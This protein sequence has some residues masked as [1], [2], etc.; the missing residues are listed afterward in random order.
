MTVEVARTWGNVDGVRLPKEAYYAT[1]VI[2]SDD[3]AVH[4]IGHWT[5]PA[6]TVKTVYV[7]SNC[8]EVELLVNGRSLGKGSGLT[9]LCLSSGM[10]RLS[11]GRSRELG[12][13]M[14]K[15]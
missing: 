15:Q 14:G 10:C 12:M 2:W 1:Q 9:R 11:R 7:M 3:P 4:I 5:Y 6:K 13:T 8:D